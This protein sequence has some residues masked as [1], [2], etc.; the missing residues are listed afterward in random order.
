MN[1]KVSRSTK[2][3]TVLEDRSKYGSGPT[4]PS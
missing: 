3:D 2:S 1:N 4:I